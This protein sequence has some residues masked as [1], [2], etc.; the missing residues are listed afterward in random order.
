MTLNIFRKNDQPKTEDKEPLN[1][2]NRQVDE[3][4]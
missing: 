3:Q 4:P 1:M 2:N